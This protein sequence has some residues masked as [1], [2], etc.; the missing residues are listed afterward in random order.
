MKLN[1]LYRIFKQP[2]SPPHTSAADH[3]EFTVFH[4]VPPEILFQILGGSSFY[5]GAT[6]FRT[7]LPAFRHNKNV[8]DVVDPAQ[9]GLLTIMRVCKVFREI[10]NEIL[11]SRP[12]LTSPRQI[13]LFTRTMRRFPH[14]RSIVKTITVLDQDSSL[15]ARNNAATLWGR[16]RYRPK[17]DL[18]EVF[19]TCA[20]VDVITISTR[21][22]TNTSILP[23]DDEFFTCSTLSTRLRSLTIYGS[24][25]PMFCKGRSFLDD[26]VNLPVL[27]F[28]CLREVYLVSTVPFPSFP[29]LRTLLIAQ[30]NNL[31]HSD[32]LY[33]PP[34]SIPVLEILEVYGN[35]FPLKLDKRSLRRLKVLHH[36]GYEDIPTI[37]E[38]LNSSA[39]DRL[40]HLAIEW[41]GPK[42]VMQ[43]PPALDSLTILVTYIDRNPVLTQNLARYLAA[44]HTLKRLVIRTESWDLESNFDDLV[45]TARE[46]C[47]ERGIEFSMFED[48]GF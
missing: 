27:E 7:E 34:A 31:S 14:L 37:A 29:R 8:V 22:R 3:D 32:T 42:F 30:S 17:N 5:S 43:F 13:H 20:Q 4:R 10:G 9:L 41:V 48:G 25:S 18:I 6:R 2:R 33:I 12:Y 16:H 46:V 1:F 40:E 11:Y 44:S 24:T 39:V 23:L 28:L 38:W 35:D 21:C 47:R 26:N 15:F 19:V 45:R 36:C